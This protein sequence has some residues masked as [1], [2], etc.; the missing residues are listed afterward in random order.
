MEY[1]PYAKYNKQHLMYRLLHLKQ[2]QLEYG[3]NDPKQPH[4]NQQSI[5]K[6]TSNYFFRI[7]VQT[8]PDQKKHERQ[9]DVQRL[10][11]GLVNGR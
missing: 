7:I 2:I 6:T 11:N 1:N 5:S 4:P 9:A 8:K 3:P 10:N